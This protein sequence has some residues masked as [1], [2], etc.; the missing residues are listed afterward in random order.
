MTNLFCPECG[1]QN[2]YLRFFKSMDI[3]EEL[4]S[5]GA[6]KEK[7]DEHGNS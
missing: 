6:H 5:I 7:A 3:S 4:K 1:R 2:T